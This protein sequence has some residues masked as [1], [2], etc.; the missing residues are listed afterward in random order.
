MQIRATKSDGREIVNDVFL[1]TCYD[2]FGMIEFVEEALDDVAGAIEVFAEGWA[3][4][5]G[6]LGSSGATIDQSKSFNS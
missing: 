5:Q 4:P 6:L 1:D 2:C 3:T